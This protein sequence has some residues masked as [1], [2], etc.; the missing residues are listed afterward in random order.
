M[1]LGQKE[2]GKPGRKIKKGCEEGLSGH[3][4]QS[5]WLSPL[6]ALKKKQM[7][8]GYCF[9]PLGLSAF[10]LSFPHILGCEEFE[11]GELPDVFP[12]DLTFTSRYFPKVI[13]LQY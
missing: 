1:R 12:N 8:F 4:L 6:W 5:G 3:L 10:S 11:N 13:G 2:K 9:P 7:W